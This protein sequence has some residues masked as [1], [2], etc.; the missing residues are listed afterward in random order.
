MSGVPFFLNGATGRTLDS[1]CRPADNC[2]RCVNQ[3]GWGFNWQFIAIAALLIIG[4]HYM[5]E[6]L[7]RIS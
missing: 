7:I 5:L 6:N 2:L 3:K 1:G 4:G